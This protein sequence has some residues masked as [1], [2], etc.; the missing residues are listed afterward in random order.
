VIEADSFA[1]Y[2]SRYRG[3]LKV[4]DV[5]PEG[6]AARQGIQRGDV[7][8]GMHHWETISLD[9]VDYILRHADFASFQPIKFYI[10]RGTE[11]LYGHMHVSSVTRR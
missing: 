1:R 4:L 8:V 6:P 2:N 11:T 5:R 3:G 10:L 7:L 9:N